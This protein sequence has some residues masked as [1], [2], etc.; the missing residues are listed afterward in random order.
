MFPS[1]GIAQSVGCN[2]RLKMEEAEGGELGACGEGK[3]GRGSVG[4]V[5]GEEE[6]LHESTEFMA[7]S[8]DAKPNCVVPVHF[9][10]GPDHAFFFPRG[11]AEAEA[12]ERVSERTNRYLC[13]K[14]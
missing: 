11:P 7:A 6:W 10:R 5:P 4:T 3:N 8:G 1:R 2:L 14:L 12:Q 13:S 9:F